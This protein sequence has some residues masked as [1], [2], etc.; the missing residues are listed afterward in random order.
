[1]KSIFIKIYIEFLGIIIL[2]CLLGFIYLQVINKIRLENYMNQT[3]KGTMSLIAEGVSRH[4]DK[5]Q[6]RWL[7]VI[8][9]L[10]DMKVQ[11]VSADKVPAKNQ[12]FYVQSSLFDHQI[13]T[14]HQLNDQSQRFIQADINEID[15]AL[16]RVTALLILNELGRYKKGE[17]SGALKKLQA[18]FGYPIARKTRNELKLTAAQTRRLNSGDIFTLI[19]A[20]TSNDPYLKVFAPYGKT[21]DVL[22]LGDIPLFIWYPP[23]LL[24]IFGFSAILMI[25]LMGYLMLRPLEKRFNFLIQSIDRIGINNQKI[26]LKQIKGNDD[27]TRLATHINNMSCRLHSLLNNQRELTHSVSHELRTPISRLRFR[28][29]LID[30]EEKAERRSERIQ[31]MQHDLTELNNLV[32]EI[33]TYAKLDSETP[34]LNIEIIQTKE[35]IQK[36]QADLDGKNMEIKLHFSIQ[37]EQFIADNHYIQRLLI[38]LIGNALRYAKSEIKISIL[39]KDEQTIW[40]IEDDGI[41]IKEA[42]LEH[43]FEPFARLDPSRNRQSGG[44]GLGL[45]ISRKIAEWHHGELYGFKSNLGGAGFILKLPSRVD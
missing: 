8:Q 9:R 14:W 24:I 27:L 28:L 2:M 34:D 17:R 39:H 32:D 7:G 36:L 5:K 40:L 25:T 43:I 35:I 4:Q 20:S 31:S 41:G 18:R 37:L 26:D 10:T 45:A 30:M 16:G 42:D 38:N 13:K 3:A 1:M 19:E 11:L 6:Q 44:Y 21:G 23:S 12:A 33:L 22:V 15:E 29:E